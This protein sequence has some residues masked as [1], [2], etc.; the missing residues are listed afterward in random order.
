MQSELP[1]IKQEADIMSILT[2]VTI[3]FPF[4]EILAGILQ[5]P[6]Y[7]HN[8]LVALNYGGVGMI[9][10]HEMTHGFDSIGR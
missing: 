3:T 4:L 10:G 8:S 2:Y 1:N 5:P 9:I 6:F 7:A